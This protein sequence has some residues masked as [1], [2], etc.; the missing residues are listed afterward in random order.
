M[1]DPSAAPVVPPPSPPVELPAWAV[2][3]DRRRAHIGRVVALIDAWAAALGVSAEERRAWHDAAR[4]HDAL[5]DAP[6]ELLR[7][8]SGDAKSDTGLLHGPATAARLAAEEGEG[9]GGGTAAGRARRDPLA[10]RRVR[11]VVAHRARPVHGRLPRAEAPIRAP[12][13]GVPRAH[14]PIRL[15]WH[16]SGGRAHADRVGPLGREGDG[17]GDGRVVEQR[18]LTRPTRRVWVGGG[19]ALV[20]A[21]GIVYGSGLTRLRRASAGRRPYAAAADIRR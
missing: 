15:R 19:V 7:D 13:S 10:H 9:E 8:L 3:S 1:T 2:V 17:G 21:L 16:L 11:R 20:A 12:G 6:E 4:W 18:A 5:R 14:G